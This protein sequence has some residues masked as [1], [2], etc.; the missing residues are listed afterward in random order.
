[1]RSTQPNIEASES[2]KAAPVVKHKRFLFAE[3]E[4][5]F[6]LEHGKGFEL[7]IFVGPTGAGKSTLITKLVAEVERREQDEMARDPDYV[8]I[9]LTSAESSGGRHG[10]DWRRLYADAAKKAG[11]PFADVR[12]PDGAAARPPRKIKGEPVTIA[13]FRSSME[14]EFE[15]RR[16]R[17]WIIDEAAHILRGANAGGVGGQF[18]VLKSIAQTGKVKILLVGSY[19]L[20]AYI[21]CSGQL[22]RRGVTVHFARYCLSDPE[23]RKNFAS[24]VSTIL[25]LCKLDGYPG[26]AENLKFYYAG[27]AGCVGIFKDWCDRAVAHASLDGRCV[28]TLE[29][30]RATRLR[31]AALQTIWRELLA[32]EA[33]FVQG[34]DAEIGALEALAVADRLT[35]ARAA[36][37]NPKATRVRGKPGIRNPTRDPVGP[38]FGTNG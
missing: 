9:V 1:M 11:D 23:D 37:E 26:V 27:C 12:R 17:Y 18:D 36:A 30:L 15:Y 25:K 35:N 4:L 24:G 5:L 14:D 3:E 22:A 19:D 13:A 6:Q 28:L 10:F 7:I 29:D 16:T 32:G 20:A 8:P 34:D 21:D 2:V 31:T 33:L 38:L